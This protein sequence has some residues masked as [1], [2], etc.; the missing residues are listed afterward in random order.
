[1]LWLCVIAVGL[2]GFLYCLESPTIVGVCD[3]ESMCV[4]FG[5]MSVIEEGTHTEIASF[6]I[7]SHRYVSIQVLEYE[8]APL[9][10]VCACMIMGLC[11]WPIY[12]G[13]VLSLISMY[14]AHTRPCMSVASWL[15]LTKV[16]YSSAANM[17]HPPTHRWHLKVSVD[18]THGH[19]L[20]Y[21]Y[22]IMW[23]WNS[24]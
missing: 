18:Y 8:C 5:S 22:G 20:L 14:V 23:Y 9:H 7:W 16:H 6:C 19:A 13:T 10:C 24:H 12:Y 21:G 1:M 3:R 11:L 15:W 17:L 4:L 2:G